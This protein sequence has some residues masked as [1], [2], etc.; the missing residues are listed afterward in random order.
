VVVGTRRGGSP[1]KWLAFHPVMLLGAGVYHGT[2]A[3]YRGAARVVP[4]TD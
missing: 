3:G 4:I 2:E 1:A